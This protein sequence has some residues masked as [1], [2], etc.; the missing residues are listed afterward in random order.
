MIEQSIASKE[1]E[2]REAEFAARAKLLETA[3]DYMIASGIV[4]PGVVIGA[5]NFAANSSVNLESE[6]NAQAEI[7]GA[8]VEE[9]GHYIDP[10]VL[11]PKGISHG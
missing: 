1:V 5:L 8:Y 9:I 7:V 6:R 2:N 11:A 4:G 10:E 3:L